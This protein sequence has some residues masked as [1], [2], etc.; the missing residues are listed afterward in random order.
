MD[1]SYHSNNGRPARRWIERTQID[2][3]A[4]GIPAGPKSLCDG[5]IHQDVLGAVVVRVQRPA[6]AQGNAHGRKIARACDARFRNRPCT[7]RGKWL[8]F[9]DKPGRRPHSRAERQ[10]GDSADG[11]CSRQCLNSLDKLIEANGLPA[12]K[13]DLLLVCELELFLNQHLRQIYFHRQDM[14]ALKTGIDFHKAMKAANQQTRADEWNERQRNFRDDQEAASFLPA[15][16]SRRSRSFLQNAVQVLFQSLYR[17][18]Q[19][20]DDSREKTHP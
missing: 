3:L 19:S 13:L 1:V 20:A 12:S 11:F 15:C 6:H 4:D 10:D 17:R 9:H 8:A 18:N 16:G 7:I 2:A 5:F 14:I